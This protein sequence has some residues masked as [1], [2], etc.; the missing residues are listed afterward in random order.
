MNIN[1]FFGI[2]LTG[3]FLAGAL[4][5]FAPCCITFLFPSYLGTIFKERKNVMFYTL[6]F[7]LGLASILIPVALGFRLFIFF[8][9]QFHRTIYFL[10]GL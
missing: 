8:F 2:S 3:S 6:V 7:A 4:A 5:L 10:G 1:F 9:D